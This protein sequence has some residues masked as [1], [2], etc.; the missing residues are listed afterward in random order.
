[1]MFLF[2]LI[3]IWDQ[4]KTVKC[5]LVFLFFCKSQI[6]QKMKVKLCNLVLQAFAFI[7]CPYF[8]D[9][10]VYW[11]LINT[12]Q[13]RY[14]GLLESCDLSLFLTFHTGLKAFPCHD[15]IFHMT[16]VLFYLADFQILIKD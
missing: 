16:T 13:I 6:C 9:Q 11:F 5:R 10:T 8:L 14:S 7:S 12:G 4:T 2:P 3:I 15:L 1:M